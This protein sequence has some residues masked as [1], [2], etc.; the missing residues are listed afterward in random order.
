LVPA[1]AWLKISESAVSWRWPGGCGAN[2]SSGDDADLAPSTRCAGVLTLV[3]PLAAVRFR[4]D[5]CG[6]V[7]VGGGG[8]KVESHM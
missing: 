5:V 3:A 2:G 6:C 8:V 1:A 4:V 7:C